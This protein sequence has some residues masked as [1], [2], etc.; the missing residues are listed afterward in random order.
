M[1]DAVVEAPFGAHPTACTPAYGIDLEHLKTYAGATG[2]EAWADLSHP[3]RRRRRRDAY[4]ANVG[5]A[6]RVAA[7]PPPIF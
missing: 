4:L 1:V 7:I 6:E 3:L 5:G 2:A